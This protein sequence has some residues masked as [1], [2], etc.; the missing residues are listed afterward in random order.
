MIQIPKFDLLFKYILQKKKL[1]YPNPQLL[2][3]C[4]FL[5]CHHGVQL[6]ATHSIV[7][8]YI[9]RSLIQPRQPICPLLQLFVLSVVIF[10]I[11]TRAFVR[12]GVLDNLA[13]GHGTWDR[14]EV[15]RELV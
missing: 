10:V 6:T 4:K 12:R 7:C 8:Y 5:I 11:P 3:Q 9:V 15:V 2:W 14:A 13:T 1:L